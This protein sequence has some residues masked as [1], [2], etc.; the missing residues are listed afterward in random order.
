MGAYRFMFR[1]FCLYVCLATHSAYASLP[2]A[3]AYLDGHKAFNAGRHGTATG[4]FTQA[5][6]AG[7]PL[8]P[9]ARIRAAVSRAAGG[10]KQGAR[11]LL[12]HAL[13]LEA[14]P[15][16][17]LAQYHLGLLM[18]QAG[19]IEAAAI[20]LNSALD[21]DADLW[22]LQD[23]RWE[24]AE[25]Y[26]Q[27]PAT[28]EFGSA[29]FRT[30]VKDTMYRRPRLEAAA[31]LA[32]S[33]DP[34]DRIAAALG[35]VYSS[36]YK[37]ATATFTSIQNAKL[38]GEWQAGRDLLAARLDLVNG[39]LTRGRSTLLS[40]ADTHPQTPW[41]AQALYYAGRSF[42]DT[43]DFA[44]AEALYERLA[45]RYAGD[46]VVG[47]LKWR[48]AEVYGE[49]KQLEQSATHFR[50]LAMRH[51]DHPR[52]AEALLGAA[53]GFRQ[54][55]R[56]NDAL[57]FYGELVEQF[58]MS[59]HAPEGAYTAGK[60]LL[61]VDK[62]EE[63]IDTFGVGAEIGIGNY[64][65]HRAAELRHELL[66]SKENLTTP[67][68]ADGARAF[69]RPVRVEGPTLEPSLAERAA[70]DERFARLQF[71]GRYGLPEAEWEALALF[72]NDL[73]HPTQD[74]LAIY[75]A[76]G[77]AGVAYSAM[78]WAD[79]LGW[80]RAGESGMPGP[81]RLR[82]SFPLA[83]WEQVSALGRA[84]GVDP[85]LMLA[86]AKQES[87]YRPALSSHAGASGVMQVMP[88]TAEWLAKVEP[89][90]TAE[91]AGNLMVPVH[92]LRLGAYYLQRMIERS[93]GNLVYALASY[94]AGP[95]NCDKWR[96]QFGNIDMATFV[97]RIPFDETRHYVKKVLGNYAAYHS[98][99]APVN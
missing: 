76:I 23:V 33:T 58:P 42:L 82:V 99:Y 88:P 77:E 69:V 93:N 48:I 96:R 18:G 2:G 80:G 71:F 64:Y 13:K 10:D 26:L 4:A 8:A 65:G 83:Y 11:E 28:R 52:A 74:E 22:W 62:P 70:E 95:G 15:W 63:A 79:H 60:L 59:P 57:T 12:E 56:R 67:F 38:T 19:E 85:Y 25:I 54:A 9:Y 51:P 39:Q 27:A 32:S 92:S 35:M 68:R 41:A 89:N 66:P 78:Q 3:T 37:D 73:S 1:W 17:P 31:I 50:A 91:D 84:T 44:Q 6:E 5:A 61:D 20:L 81:N 29:F 53:E 16:T 97:E 75:A 87:T 30:V 21:V 34:A 49:R 14:G 86:V 45:E 46:R 47:D 94:N 43:G 24:A 72:R 7:G 90:L 55:G 36:S 98:L 40:I